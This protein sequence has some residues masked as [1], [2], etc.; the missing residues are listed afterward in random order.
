[1]RTRRVVIWLSL[2]PSPSPE[3]HRLTLAD[4]LPDVLLDAA[5]N[6]VRDRLHER[7]VGVHPLLVEVDG[8]EE[9]QLE[10]R[11]QVAEHA[12][13]P[14]GGERRRDREVEKAGEPLKDVDLRE[15]RS[16]LLG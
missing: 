16:G 9:A 6:L 11:G 12:E 14:E 4:H 8:L 1:M 15:D 3:P 5:P 10:L 13:Q 7:L 2:S